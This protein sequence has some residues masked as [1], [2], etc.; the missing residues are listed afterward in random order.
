MIT[1]GTHIEVQAIQ[2]RKQH[3]WIS[4]ARLKVI[5]RVAFEQAKIVRHPLTC[6]KKLQPSLP[7]IVRVVS[8]YN[9]KN[10]QRPR[11]RPVGMRDEALDR[12]RKDIAP[13]K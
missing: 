4:L 3:P 8:T 10:I 13:S 6:L 5:T 11:F 7:D 2:R 9:P 12:P 1:V